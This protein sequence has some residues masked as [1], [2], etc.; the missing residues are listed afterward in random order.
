MRI[1]APGLMR[2]TRRSWQ[3]VNTAQKRA[4]G[5]CPSVLTPTRE[6]ESLQSKDRFR[7]RQSVDSGQGS[8]Q[9][10]TDGDYLKAW[11]DIRSL[12]WTNRNADPVN[13]ALMSRS[14]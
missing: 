7:H 9:F 6:G 8:L 12:C 11:V 1:H 5:M 3:M 4:K 10:N 2:I 14:W 13:S